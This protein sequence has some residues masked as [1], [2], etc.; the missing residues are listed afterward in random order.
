M[1]WAAILEARD[2]ELK[3]GVVSAEIL[4]MELS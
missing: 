2:T 4:W 3:Q 1:L